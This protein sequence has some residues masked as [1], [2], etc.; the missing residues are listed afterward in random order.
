MVTV[1]VG[2]AVVAEETVVG[3]PVGACVKLK[4][5]GAGLDSAGLMVIFGGPRRK[6]LFFSIVQCFTVSLQ[7][8]VFCSYCSGPT[9]MVSCGDFLMSTQPHCILRELDGEVMASLSREIRG[10]LPL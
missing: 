4:E 2:G 8:P 1:V 6:R 3:G 10:K 7:N 5:G 9:C